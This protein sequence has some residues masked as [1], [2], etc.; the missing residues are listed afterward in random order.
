MPSRFAMFQLTRGALTALVAQYL[1]L[2]WD[3]VFVDDPVDTCTTRC[4]LAASNF[5]QATHDGFALAF[6]E[7]G[8]CFRVSQC[9]AACVNRIGA[10]VDPGQF[11]PSNKRMYGCVMP[12]G[13]NATV[14]EVREMSR[15]SCVAVSTVQFDTALTCL[16]ATPSTPPGPRWADAAQ[17]HV[18][19]SRSKHTTDRDCCAVDHLNAAVRRISPWACA[20]AAIAGMVLTPHTACKTWAVARRSK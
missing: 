19:P 13:A 16:D 4:G 10:S 1:R 7:P 12:V 17:N 2:R 18:S 3:V 11:D 5:A 6:G 8:A 9:L 14:V 15:P 20:C